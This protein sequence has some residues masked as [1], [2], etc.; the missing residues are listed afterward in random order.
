MPIN[1]DIFRR[2]RTKFSQF[3]GQKKYQQ[4]VIA[5]QQTFSSYILWLDIVFKPHD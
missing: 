4:F 5:D 2:F 3:Y 1:A